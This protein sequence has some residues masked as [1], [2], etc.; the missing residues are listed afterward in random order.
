MTILCIMLVLTDAC[1]GQGPGL[2]RSQT[3]A[4]TIYSRIC[5]AIAQRSGNAD[6]LNS[7]ARNQ[8]HFVFLIDTSQAHDKEAF[9]ESAKKFCIRFVQ[10]IGQDQDRLQVPRELRSQV[11]LY[12]YQLSL[13]TDPAHILERGLVFKG[14]GVIQKLSAA[15]P[16]DRVPMP[17][18]RLRGHDS[19]GSRYTLFQ[20][21]SA[22][23]GPIETVIIQI[24]NT[25]INQDPDHP[26]NDRK[27]RAIDARTGLMEGQRW[28]PYDEAGGVFSSDDPGA[29]IAPYDLF[30]WTYGP[31]SFN[32]PPPL[33]KRIGNVSR[34]VPIK[35]PSEPN[36]GFWVASLLAAGIVGYCWTYFRHQYQVEL[37]GGAAYARRGG[38]VELVTS[39]SGKAGQHVLTLPP[40]LAGN[41]NAGEVIGKVEIPWFG[42]PLLRPAKPWTLLAD[43]TPSAQSAIRKS[44]RYRFRDQTRETRDISLNCTRT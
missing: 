26:G 35:T 27:I 33:S 30:I 34:H 40:S 1:M 32:V 17:G 23:S 3:V 15:I 13:I 6:D 10:K 39:G 25:S 31:E 41:A 7:I 16:S 14:G 38:T 22:V 8:T 11:S 19:S 43:E 36:F 4:D 18:E 42:E 5:K 44:C 20:R 12:P 29:G 28:I 21:L 2:T 37:D 9:T 24:T